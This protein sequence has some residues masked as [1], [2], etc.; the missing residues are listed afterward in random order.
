MPAIAS[1]VFL[2]VAPP[3]GVVA[4]KKRARQSSLATVNDAVTSEPSVSRV[5]RVVVWALLSGS[6]ITSPH[7]PVARSTKFDTFPAAIRSPKRI[8][9]DRASVDESRGGERRSYSREFVD[10]N[11]CWRIASQHGE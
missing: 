5:A 4:L 3:V 10:G 11:A 6:R 2:G 1:M 9:G 7:P 8:P